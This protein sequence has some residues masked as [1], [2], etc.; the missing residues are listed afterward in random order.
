MRDFEALMASF[1]YPIWT[2]AF[3]AAVAVVFVVLVV[4]MLGGGA[5]MRLTGQVVVAAVVVGAAWLAAD[6]VLRFELASD[7]HAL[8]QRSASL[9]AQAVAPGSALA[10][11][12][13]MAG[14]IADATC[15]PS[16]FATPSGVAAAVSY[17]AARLAFLADAAAFAQRGDRGYEAVIAPLRQ[18]LEADRFGLVAHVLAVRDNCTELQCEAF[19][20]LRD[21]RRVQ[22]NLKAGTFDALVGRYAAA[23]PAKPAPAVSAAASPPPATPLPVV[24]P[25]QVA[26]PPSPQFDFPSAASIPPVSIMNPEPG[27]VAAP[28]PAPR[29]AGAVPVPP[30]RAPA[31]PRAAAPPPARSAPVQI[32]PPVTG[33]ETDA[34]SLH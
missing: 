15:E 24:P 5:L 33:A 6:R 28:A 3:G 20:L 32:A 26:T 18:A 2:A 17:T 21:P 19:A 27:P 30:R 10:C 11:L 4:R 22:A 25:A 29:P 7:R 13:A 31:S 9:T 23:W 12:D 34:Q 14:E 16:L 8:A 1:P